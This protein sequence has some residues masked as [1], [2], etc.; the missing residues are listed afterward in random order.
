MKLII[1]IL[2]L[3]KF[4]INEI[5][6]QSYP[7]EIFNICTKYNCPVTRGICAKDNKCECFEGYTTLIENNFHY[8]QCN[9]EKKSKVIAFLFEVIIGFGVGHLYL[10]NIGIAISKLIFCFMTAFFICF[11][12]HF[13]KRIK[14]KLIRRISPYTQSVFGIIYFIW[15]AVDGVFIG[16]SL[17]KDSNGVEMIEW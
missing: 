9:Y 16:L 8:Y 11:F 14:S 12:P 2:V 1:Y 13:A 10:G 17:Y 4:L 6:S 7:Y 5:Q 15:Q 3:V